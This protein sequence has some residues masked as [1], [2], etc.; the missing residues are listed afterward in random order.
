MD[1]TGELKLALW[2]NLARHLQPSAC[3]ATRFPFIAATLPERIPPGL[4][5]T[6]MTVSQVSPGSANIISAAAK[7]RSAPFKELRDRHVV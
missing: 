3:T 1:R 4:E 7:L 6:E 2:V 5:V